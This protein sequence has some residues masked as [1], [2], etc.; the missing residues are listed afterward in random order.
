[1]AKVRRFAEA[2]GMGDIIDRHLT[3]A[4]I[5]YRHLGPQL[6][7]EV[8]ERRV[9]VA[10]FSPERAHRDAE[11]RRDMLQAGVASQGRK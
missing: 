3:I 9:F 7:E 6:V 11:M 4:Q 10:Q 8:A 2:Q 1:M 5:L